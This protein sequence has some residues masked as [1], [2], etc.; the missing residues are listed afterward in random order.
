MDEEETAPNVEEESKNLL[1]DIQPF[2][3][4]LCAVA[5]SLCLRLVEPDALARAADLQRG[6]RHPPL[7]FLDLLAAF[8]S[9]S[10]L[11]LFLVLT[12]ISCVLSALLQ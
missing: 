7:V 5:S 6:S 2:E 3:D 4:F 9:L 11:W 8:P 1:V 10:H 12:Q